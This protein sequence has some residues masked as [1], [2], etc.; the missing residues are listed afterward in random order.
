MPPGKIDVKRQALPSGERQ[1]GFDRYLDNQ[2]VRN[3][4]RPRAFENL[5]GIFA[6]ANEAI[7]FEREPFPP[8]L[9]T[10]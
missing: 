5:S 1:L 10:V 8:V 4:Q 9:R 6:M 3:A 2:R 7:V